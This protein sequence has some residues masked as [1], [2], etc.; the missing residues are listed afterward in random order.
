MV[1]IRLS[2]TGKKNRIMYR[3]IAIDERKKRDGQAI[4]ILGH[5]DPH[6]NPP[7]LIIKKDRIEG[8]IRKGAQ[9]TDGVKKLYNKAS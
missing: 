1:K 2:Q 5:Y 6:M 7:K 9:L 4:E 8:W 3:I